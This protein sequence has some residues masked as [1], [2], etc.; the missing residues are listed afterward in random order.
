MAIYKCAWFINFTGI[1]NGIT[2]TPLL[3]CFEN[4]YPITEY[5]HSENE[6]LSDKW[7]IEKA[8]LKRQIG[9]AHV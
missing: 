1:G 3:Q 2:I 9:R 8:R 4:S 5:F 6:I 7:F